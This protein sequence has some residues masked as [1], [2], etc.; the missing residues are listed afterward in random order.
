MW[1]NSRILACVL[2]IGSGLSSP[3]TAEETRVAF[4]N[5]NHDVNQPVEIV[6]DSFSLSQNRGKA[7]FVGNVV[8]GQG[9][10]R[11]SASKIT[12]EYVVINGEASGDIDRMI[13]SGNVTLISGTEAIEA[14]HAIYS[15][16]KGVI[17]MDGSVLMTQGPSTALSGE[18]VTINLADGSAKIEGRVRTIFKAGSSE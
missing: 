2:V 7:E 14:Q 13:A 8:A 10:V 18:K 12:V 5:T 15:P 16:N 3:A 17:T 4:G 11:L 9:N 1:I 6:S